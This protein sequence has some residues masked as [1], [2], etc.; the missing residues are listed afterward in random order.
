MNPAAKFILFLYLSCCSAMASSSSSGSRLNKKHVLVLASQRTNYEA[1][2]H[3]CTI[4]VRGIEYEVEAHH[5]TWDNIRLTS[6]GTQGGLCVDIAPNPRPLADS[7][8]GEKRSIVADF[9][10]L[11]AGCRGGPQ[12]DW[13]SKLSVISHSGVA[14]L[15][16]IDSFFL[17]QDKAR[18][19]GKLIGVKKKL[20]G[21][22]N[23]PL[24]AE[25]CYSDWAAA[26]FPP[27]FPTVV[28]VGTASGGLGKARVL[29]ADGWADMR[30][31]LAMQSDVFTTQNLVQWTYDIRVQK[32]GSHIRAFRRKG[33]NW[34][35]N[36]D[37]AM[38]D[39]DVEVEER[40]RV[41][42]SEAAAA[43]EQDICA[44][45]ILQTEDGSEY[46]LECNS[47]AIGLNARHA[48][49]DEHR[50]RDLV[51]QKMSEA[52]EADIPASDTPADDARP[53]AAPQATVEGLE[54]TILSL[55]SDLA[56][57]EQRRLQEVRALEQQLAVAQE[58]KP[59][60]FF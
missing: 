1:L 48:E 3:G 45:D 59:R 32:I 14:T 8:Q 2:F 28:K 29:D 21:F 58:K 47:S 55:R 18:L 42:I 20:G 35:S 50:I 43:L 7:R 40:W 34:K 22:K 19:N 49:E 12:V 41:W 23:F 57:L 31:V 53:N 39:E 16:S 52:F 33:K 9:V 11:R 26:T 13:R 60:R 6:Y 4:V 46:I 56:S 51:L 24:I 10:L 38:T 36:V 5:T 15:N 37:M 30:S 17:S 54:A 25:S 27:D 44:M